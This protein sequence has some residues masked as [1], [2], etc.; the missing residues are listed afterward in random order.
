MV[1]PLLRMDVGAQTWPAEEGTEGNGGPFMIQ[2]YIRQA[3]PQGRKSDGSTYFRCPECKGRKKLE[4]SA[5][6]RV[7]S[8]HKCGVGG[9]LET[10]EVRCLR[11]ASSLN[12]RPPDLVPA[13]PGSLWWGYLKHGRKLPE[14]LIRELRPHHGGPDPWLVYFPFYDWGS[15]QPCYFTSRTVLPGAGSV[16][17]HPPTEMYPRRKSTV[18]WGLH[19]IHKPLPVVVVCEGVLD[20]VWLPNGVA[21]LGKTLSEAQVEI[22]NRITTEEIVVMLD[23]DVDLSAHRMADKIARRSNRH[24]SVV[25]LPTGVDPDDLFSKGVDVYRYLERRR[26]TI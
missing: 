17:W 4:V 25:E 23:G 1:L 26:R 10:A 21:G 12:Q 8:C 7:W 14:R 19:R 20:A 13:E 15:E 16:Y 9:R 5:G 2:D 6:R 24:V 11:I 18:L 22:L 3:I